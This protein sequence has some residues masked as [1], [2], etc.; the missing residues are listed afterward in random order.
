MSKGLTRSEA[1]RILGFRTVEGVRHLA[2]NGLLH[3]TR[4][5]LGIW[6]FD[7]DEVKRLKK[8]RDD[9]GY[10]TR[11]K[12][13]E[14]LKEDNAIRV[15]H[16]KRREAEREDRE[17]RAL[18]KRINDEAEREG[19]LKRE[20]EDQLT[21]EVKA[22]NSARLEDFKRDYIPEDMVAGILGVEGPESFYIVQRLVMTGH[23]R[24]FPSPKALVV[25]WGT[26]YG[27][28][29]YAEETTRPLLEGAPFYLRSEVVELR[30][31][32][33]N[34][35]LR[36]ATR[37]SSVFHDEDSKDFDKSVAAPLIRLLHA[38]IELDKR[39]K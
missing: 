15:A 18:W 34:S 36:L 27:G 3:Q 21:R 28:A 33:V 6:R 25:Q 26:L 8:Q 23:L 32:G 37:R 19:R 24:E 2:K 17:A 29:P 9:T 14:K 38:F 11:L 12:K 16:A 35:V 10:P 5:E 4:D 31:K 39:P 1:A 30:D 7:A 22:K 13:E 20:R